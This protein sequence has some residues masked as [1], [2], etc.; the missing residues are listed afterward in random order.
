MLH[1]GKKVE[2]KSNKNIFPFVLTFLLFAFFLNAFFY[3]IRVACPLIRSDAWRFLNNPI[4]KWKREGFE[5][6]D[7]FVKS[8]LIDNVVKSNIVD[9]A[10]PLNKL[11]LYINYRW[12]SLDLTYEAIFGFMALLLLVASIVLIYHK[13][14]K[15]NLTN[16]RSLLLLFCALITLISMNVTE[17]YT[18]SLVSFSNTYILLPLLFICGIWEFIHFN[19]KHTIFF[20]LLG[21]IL[22]GDT[23]TLVFLTSLTPCLLLVAKNENLLTKKKIFF[24]LTLG[25]ILFFF[26]YMLINYDQ[27]IETTST[28]TTEG[29]FSHQLKDIKSYFEAIRIS[30]SSSIMH[31]S[32]IDSFTTKYTYELSIL[33]ASVVLFFYLRFFYKI[34]F[35]NTKIQFYQY[36]CLY[37]LIRAGLSIVLIFLGRVPEFSIHCFNETRYVQT[38]QLIPFALFLNYAFS[39]RDKSIKFTILNSTIILIFV[40]TYTLLQIIYVNRAYLAEPWISK[41]H[42]QQALDI[43]H[44]SLNS[45]NNLDECTPTSVVICTMKPETRNELLLFL[46]NENLNIFNHTF[47]W[48]HRL[49]PTEKNNSQ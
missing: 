38:Y 10:Q 7:L 19:K 34:I 32:Q 42:N 18:W 22:I 3:L 43:G 13:H 2:K 39:I 45:T 48:R 30:F 31:Y 4:L 24:S 27:V 21:L 33:L 8:P 29:T 11:L 15:E 17:M 9:H 49:F 14:G 37:I 16:W 1:D 44:Y 36:I 41:F 40:F 5:I 20:I 6:T 26:Y 47:Q 25:W 12:L 28:H 46:K 35:S 23:G